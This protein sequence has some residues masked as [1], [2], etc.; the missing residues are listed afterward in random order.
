MNEFIQQYVPLRERKSKGFPRQ[1]LQL[2]RKCER[3]FIKMKKQ[4]LDDNINQYKCLFREYR[5]KIRSTFLRREQKI[6]ISTNIKEFWNYVKSKNTV[7]SEIPPIVSSTGD[8]LFC[9]KDIANEFNNYFESVFAIDNNKKFVPELKTCSSISEIEIPA[10]AIYEKLKK[11]RPKLSYGADGIPSIF[12]QKLALVLSYPL[13]LVFQ[14]SLSSGVLPAIWKQSVVVPIHKKNA[15]NRVE[16]Y[17]PISLTCV[18]CRIMESFLVNR[19]RRHLWEESLISDA[20]F[21]FLNNRGTVTQ[22]LEFQQALISEQT[23]K[24]S[25]DVIYLDISKAFDT[26]CHRRLKSILLNYGING[27]IYNWLTSFLSQRTQFVRIKN[28]FSTSSDVISGVPQGSCLGPLLFLL[29]I[30]DAKS[31]IQYSNF[32]MYADDC[33]LYLSSS[34]DNYHERLQSD[35]KNL[36]S[37]LENRQ[38]QLATNKCN[39][40]YVGKQNMGYQYK[41]NDNTLNKVNVIKD[42]GLHISNDLKVTNHVRI[43]KRKCMAIVNGMFRN[44]RFSKT[45]FVTCFKSLV[46]PILEYASEAFINMNK[47]DATILESVQ[48]YFTKRIIPN[49]PYEQRMRILKLEPL[50]YRRIV[51]D[52]SLA[53][54]YVYGYIFSKDIFH[55]YT[56]LNRNSQLRSNGIKLALPTMSEVKNK[57]VTSRITNIWNSLPS[58]IVFKYNNCNFQNSLKLWLQRNSHLTTT[59]NPL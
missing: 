21:G 48:R 46:I 14:S 32:L 18:S 29:Y 42:L 56:T 8:V 54:K 53:H 16:N 49:S 58:E 5:N 39:V 34:S 27:S 38:L 33:K 1:L 43:T 51:K 19:I 6:C 26:V 41:L 57:F 22:L 35:L 28:T 10:Y 55:L 36:H 20:Q 30:N 44:F 17:R 47:T 40:M 2:R 7:K 15:K 25:T 4:P 24:K 9:D 45:N 3:A 13:S 23:A 50:W 52:L 12:Y 37:W 59:M 11:M 31:A